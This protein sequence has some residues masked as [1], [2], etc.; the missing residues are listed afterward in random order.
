MSAN[1]ALHLESKTHHI[2]RHFSFYKYLVI[3]MVFI[4]AII[5]VALFYSVV[6]PKNSTPQ[7][8][9]NSL[10]PSSKA[11]TSPTQT[12]PYKEEYQNPFEK[13]TD[14]KNPFDNI[15]Q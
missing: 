6:S 11:P 8:K 12:I 9:E 4:I 5:G 15:S 7:I 1:S 2:Q 10:A 14:Y 3:L 13:K